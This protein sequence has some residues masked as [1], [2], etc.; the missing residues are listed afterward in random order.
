MCVPSWRLVVL[1]EPPH[2]LARLKLWAH[3]CDRYTISMIVHRHKLCTKLDVMKS[4]P[5]D[6]MDLKFYHFMMMLTLV[7]GEL[8]ACFAFFVSAPGV[9]VQYSGFD[10]KLWLV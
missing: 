9:C 5:S 2:C 10:L 1:G 7:G 4:V 3:I 6:A 8:A